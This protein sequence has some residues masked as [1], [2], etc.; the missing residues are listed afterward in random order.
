MEKISTLIKLNKKSTVEFDKKFST[1]TEK[2]R[3]ENFIKEKENLCLNQT[4]IFPNSKNKNLTTMIKK[5]ITDTSNPIEIKEILQLMKKEIDFKLSDFSVEFKGFMS[6]IDHVFKGDNDDIGK[7]TINL[8]DSKFKE[9]KLLKKSFSNSFLSIENPILPIKEV[10]KIKEDSIEKF[11]SLK[12][13]VTEGFKNINTEESTL[14]KMINFSS[15]SDTITSFPKG[16]IIPSIIHKKNTL[17][18]NNYCERIINDKFII[19]VEDNSISSNN[20]QEGPSVVDFNKG[21]SEYIEIPAENQTFS[22]DKTLKESTLTKPDRL[23]NTL[24]VKGNISIS[25]HHLKDS[26]MFKLNKKMLILKENL[27]FRKKIP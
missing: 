16:F 7:E 10:L 4:F 21:E 13:P 6:K 23:S 2:I 3:L 24:P 25:K 17:N 26:G 22:F 12:R 5:H 11:N 19:V 9:G 14:N 27:L 15:E 20:F 18:D 8:Q 1:L